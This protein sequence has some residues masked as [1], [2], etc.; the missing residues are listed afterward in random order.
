MQDSKC[1]KSKKA[2]VIYADAYSSK[3]ARSFNFYY[4]D[5]FASKTQGLASKKVFASL[6]L[7]GLG[8]KPFAPLADAIRAIG[9][10]ASSLT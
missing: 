10:I 4:S 6:C 5:F 8:A 2:K 1:L 7:S 9:F 3:T